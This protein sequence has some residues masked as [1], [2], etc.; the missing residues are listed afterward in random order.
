MLSSETVRNPKR[1]S[2][3]RGRLKQATEALH[4]SIERCLDLDNHDWTIGTYRSFLM[5]MWGLFAPLERALDAI[6]W[7]NSGIDMTKR[8]KVAW[9][10]SDLKQ[11]SKGEIVLPAL[12]MC[13]CLPRLNCVE[14]GLGALYV[15][16]GSTLGG[17]IVMRKLQRV[18][19]ISPDAGG[20]FFSSY[21]DNTGSMWRM[22]LEVLEHFAAVTDA[23]IKIERSAI[24]TF[25]AFDLWLSASCGRRTYDARD[26]HV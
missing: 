16:E 20:R 17:Q 19:S 18:L 14:E 12:E 15:T 7:R 8:R 24:Q 11:L 4:N 22:Y 21:G 6:D 26:C 3:L 10:E 5:R 2:G 25:T 1:M 23:D 9:L 13:G